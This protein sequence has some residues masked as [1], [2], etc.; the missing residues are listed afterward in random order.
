MESYRYPLEDL[1]SHLRTSAKGLT[2][3]EVRERLQK[4]GRNRLAEEKRTSRF[5]V[6]LRQFKSPLIY[7][8]LLAAVVTGI[9][10]DSVDSGVILAV[11][12]FNAVIGFV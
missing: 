9:M 10:Q 2:D 7:I 5:A 3:E 11:L 6:F 4:F 12:V 1:L 8:L